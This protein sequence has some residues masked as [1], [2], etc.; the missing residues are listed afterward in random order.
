MLAS[1]SSSTSAVRIKRKL[2]E[3]GIYS[4]VI[5]TPKALTKDG[6]GYSLSFDEPAKSQVE[7]AAAEL[8]IKIRAFYL[9]SDNSGKKQYKKFEEV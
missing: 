7:K 3:S 2:Y 5:Q 8:G 6:C 4:S 1:V 9:E